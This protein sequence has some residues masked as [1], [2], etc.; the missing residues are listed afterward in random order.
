MISIRNK[1]KKINYKNKENLRNSLRLKKFKK[2]RNKVVNFIIW[3]I[4]NN[5]NMKLVKILI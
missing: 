5:N 3:I 2:N 4:V 1:I